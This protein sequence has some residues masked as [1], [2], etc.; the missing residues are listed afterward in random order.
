MKSQLRPR[1]RL[2]SFYHQSRFPSGE[3]GHVKFEPRLAIRACL[4][5]EFSGIG[6]PIDMRGHARAANRL[7]IFFFSYGYMQIRAF[8][9]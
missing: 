4:R 3:P 6:S 7:S 8:A 2:R 9:R 1:I 5:G